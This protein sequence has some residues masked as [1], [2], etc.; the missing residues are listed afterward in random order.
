MNYLKILSC[1]LRSLIIRYIPYKITVGENIITIELNNVDINRGL[2]E[3]SLTKSL[4][5]T[6]YYYKS[7]FNELLSVENN[8]LSIT[9]KMSFRSERGWESESLLLHQIYTKEITRTN[10]TEYY[11]TTIVNEIFKIN[12]EY[13][14]IAIQNIKIDIFAVKHYPYQSFFEA[15]IIT[16]LISC[17]DMNYD[18]LRISLKRSLNEALNTYREVLEELL[19]S[20][21]DSEI[22]ILSRFSFTSKEGWRAESVFLYQMNISRLNIRNIVENYT[23]GV[24]L[25]LIRKD[26][27]YDIVE[28][29]WV[30]TKI[31]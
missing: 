31:F 26:E 17:V 19:S 23:N 27:K 24:M 3:R 16:I 28:V 15:G 2:I 13:D 9:T 1:K 5:E 22:V 14:I 18:T 11:S 29:H 25:E 21:D 6:L 8:E 20:Y 10:L 12:I 30:E 4:N 7:R